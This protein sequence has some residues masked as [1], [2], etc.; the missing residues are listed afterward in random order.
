MATLIFASMTIY[1]TNS[2]SLETVL[3]PTAAYQIATTPAI[4]ITQG[5]GDYA[6]NFSPDSTAVSAGTTVIWTDHDSSVPVSIHFTRVPA[7]AGP[8][9]P[10]PSLNQGDSFRVF[11]TLPGL[12]LYESTH[13]AQGSTLILART[14]GMIVVNS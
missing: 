4:A 10:S 11:L 2:T 1:L 13:Y 14:I 3:S 8:I 12:Y 7:G 5:L 9:A 6:I